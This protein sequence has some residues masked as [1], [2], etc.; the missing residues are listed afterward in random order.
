MPRSGGGVYSPPAGTTAVT[1]TVIESA[2]YN[3]FVADVTA[4]LNSPRPVVA[5]G[6]GASTAAG[7]RTNLGGTATGVAVFTA[8]DAAA[9]RTAISAQTADP[10]LTGLAGLDAAGGVLAQTAADT[11]AKRTFAATSP[12]AVANGDGVAGNPTFSVALATQAQAQAGVDNVGVMTA[13]RTREAIDARG[14]RFVG[15]DFIPGRN[16]RITFAHGLPARPFMM[17]AILRCVA[18][19]QGYAIGD[20]VHLSA[21]IYDVNSAQGLNLAADA[22]TI[23]TGIY[24]LTVRHKT[25]GV[26]SAAWAEITYASWRMK[27]VAW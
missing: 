1:Q 18:A 23:Y 13:L 11:F 2:K 19:D 22:T 21:G 24:Y 5:G 26:D 10:T 6:T 20:E 3:A 7:A 14:P 4:D 9:A 15:A 17:N 8:A 16:Q 27:I 12:I 25:T